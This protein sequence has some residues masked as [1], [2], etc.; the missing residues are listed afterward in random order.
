MI[1]SLIQSNP[2]VAVVWIVAI[3]LSLTVHE[4][5]HALVGKLRGDRTAELE[6]RLTLNPLAHI[7]WFGFLAVVLIGFGW[8]KPV[9]YN[10][11]NLK[12]PKWDSVWVALAGPGSNLVFAVVC[13]TLLRVL[14]A[15]G[16]ISGTN[17]L[18]I[19]LVLMVLL[20]L[21]LLLFNI[22]PVHPL[23]GTKLLF[24]IFDQP[25]HERLRFFVATQGP[26]VLLFLV[27]LSLL[28]PFNVFGFISL[29]AFAACDALTDQSCLGFLMRIFYP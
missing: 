8:A 19:F 24:A 15:A 14:T 27:I 26:R 23:D 21:F 13:G 10:P 9:P 29:P 3:V 2:I 11:H 4:F 6:G 16:M 28:T 1:L 7:D 12:N 25:K 17:L 20:N 5:S 18:G 22:I